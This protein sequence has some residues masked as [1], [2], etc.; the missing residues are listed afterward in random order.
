MNQSPRFRF[1]RKQRPAAI[2][3]PVGFMA[4]P[5]MLLP[6]VG[7]RPELVETVY[8]QAFREALAVVRPSIL[9][10]NLCWN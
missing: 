7:A 6:Q 4:C 1:P 5:T 2:R 3:P 8:Q 10:R 9:E